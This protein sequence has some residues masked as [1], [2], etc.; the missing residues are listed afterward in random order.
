MFWAIASAP[1]SHRTGGDDS[2]SL[3]SLVPLQDD[4][5]ADLLA[6]LAPS[7]GSAAGAPAA[8]ARNRYD[9]GGIYVKVYENGENGCL[10]TIGTEVWDAAV[11]FC[12]LFSEE[13]SGVAAFLRTSFPAGGR[14]AR[15][16]ELGSGVGLSGCF[17]KTVMGGGIDLTMTDYSPE[18]IRLLLRSASLLGE[19]VNVR[20]LDWYREETYGGGGGEGEGGAG[21]AGPLYDCV[22]GTAL[23]YSP[24]HSVVADVIN[25]T[26]SPAG[27]AFILQLSTRP[28]V[29]EFLAR[30]EALDLEVKVEE[31]GE[32]VVE[33]ARVCRK[34]E[35]IGGSE[36]MRVYTIT[37]GRGS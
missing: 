17:L 24:S 3:S 37:H 27:K 36:E 35:G 1:P 11:L 21:T 20:V 16:L 32:S 15:V 30:C 5:E 34:K 12:F 29:K 13:A 23:V 6:R 22:V 33:R 4:F 28:G 18:V 25:A 14:S 2:L 26:L 9:V 10:S 8:D 7:G 31:V 19:G